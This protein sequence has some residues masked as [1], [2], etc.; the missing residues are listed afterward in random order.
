MQISYSDFK[1]YM[2]ILKIDGGIYCLGD[3][4]PYFVWLQLGGLEFDTMIESSANVSDFEANYKSFCNQIP[5]VVNGLANYDGKYLY[6]ESFLHKITGGETYEVSKKFTSDVIFFGGQYELIG[7][8]DDDIN[9]EPDYIEYMITDED[10]ILGYGAGFVLNKFIKNEFILKGNYN[11]TNIYKR[12][13][14]ATNA[15]ARV[16]N[17]LYFTLKY[18]SK[19]ISP[20]NDV[21]LIERLFPWN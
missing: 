20:D 6:R 19:G 7:N 9:G 21:T 15:A 10:N 4:A 1:N 11:N 2:D 5:K 13:I 8:I 3:T 12:D 14:V 16:P 18:V 17:Y